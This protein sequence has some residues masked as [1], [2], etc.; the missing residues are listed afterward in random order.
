MPSTKPPSIED[1]LHARAKQGFSPNLLRAKDYED[2]FLEY[3]SVVFVPETIR[4]GN[5]TTG[6]D[7]NGVGN[8]RI[9]VFADAVDMVMTLRKRGVLTVGFNDA[10]VLTEEEKKTRSEG[11]VP[12]SEMER[13]EVV[14]GVLTSGG[15]GVVN[16]TMPPTASRGK[17][18]QL[19]RGREGD[20]EGLMNEKGNGNIAMLQK[21]RD[22]AGLPSAVDWSGFTSVVKEQGT[23]GGCWAF[24]ATGLLEAHFAKRYGFVVSLSEQELLDCDKIANRGCVGGNYY[25]A[26]RDYLSRDGLASSRAYQY[27]G[28]SSGTQCRNV[29]SNLV[30][31]PTNRVVFV[32]RT[33]QA[34]ME[35]VAQGPVAVAVAASNPLF[36]YYVGGV[37]DDADLCGTSVSHAMLLVGYNT[38]ANGIDYWLLKNSWGTGWGEGGYIRMRRGSNQILSKTNGLGICGILSQANTITVAEC[39]GGDVLACLPY[40]SKE[41]C[42]TSKGCISNNTITRNFLVPPNSF[43]ALESTHMSPTFLGWI[44]A[45]GVLFIALL[46]AIVYWIVLRHRNANEDKPGLHNDRVQD[47]SEID[48]SFAHYNMV[49]DTGIATVKEKNFSSDASSTSS[50]RKSSSTSIV[51]IPVYDA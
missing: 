28:S 17:K 4:S 23:C 9:F 44:S 35:A 38:T 25:Y 19:E 30:R 41:F 6:K 31:T 14:G 18:R 1:P 43:A 46:A 2:L 15:G 29:T 22:L 16:I 42:S 50:S 45:S 27:M 20:G 33:E 24:A 32:D 5:D 36:Q 34:L 7:S 26:I 12:M 13:R 51:V 21:T 11:F 8:E 37:L 10:L 49:K 39:A 3:A 40:A 47:E 48:A